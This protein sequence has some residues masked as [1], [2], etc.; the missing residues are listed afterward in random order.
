MTQLVDDDLSRANDALAARVVSALADVGLPVRLI[1][2]QMITKPDGDPQGYSDDPYAW[3]RGA[4]VPP[5]TGAV[6]TAVDERTKGD[7]PFS[8]VCVGWKV[9]ARVAK[10]AVTEL[11]ELMETADDFPDPL[12]DR[13]SRSGRIH[14]VMQEAIRQ[15]LSDE[16]FLLEDD[17]DHRPYEMWVRD[18]ESR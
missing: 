6:V 18:H 17:T 16:G 4:A 14:T 13:M 1:H 3:N 8:R 7:E 5:P 11:V 12:P 2:E 9:S 15:I 10:A